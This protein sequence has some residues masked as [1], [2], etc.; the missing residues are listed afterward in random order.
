MPETDTNG[1][2]DLVADINQALDA[3]RE[4]AQ[5]TLT[6]AAAACQMASKPSPEL[7]ARFQRAQMR[8]QRAQFHCIIARAMDDPHI[9]ALLRL[10][11]TDD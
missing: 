10:A 1:Q 5:C 3:E 11:L 8:A 2:P 7:V 6:E 4:K 9:K